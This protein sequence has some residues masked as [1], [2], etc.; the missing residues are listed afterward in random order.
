DGASSACCR[1]RRRSRRQLVQRVGAVVADQELGAEG[2]AEGNVNEADPGQLVYPGEG[3]PRGLVGGAADLVA[4]LT[5][6]DSCAVDDADDVERGAR[7][8]ESL[9]GVDDEGVDAE[10]FV[11]VGG[12]AR[13]L[14]D[15]AARRVGRVF[16]GFYAAAGECPALPAGLVPVGVQHALVSDDDPVRPDPHVHATTLVR[17]W[18]ARAWY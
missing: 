13:L 2:V 11:Q 18:R 5:A 1:S 17:V 6:G 8:G 15:L 12:V 9:L 7:V 4:Q 14:K 3:E 10:Q 16:P